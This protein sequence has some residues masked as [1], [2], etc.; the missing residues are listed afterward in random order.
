M[1]PR[2]A[3]GHLRRKSLQF[4]KDHTSRAISLE[5]MPTRAEYGQRTREE[6]S[7][8]GTSYTYHQVADFSFGA[9]A[10]CEDNI[11]FAMDFMELITTFL[12][13]QSR[14]RHCRASKRGKESII[15]VKQTSVRY[16]YITA[17]Q[18]FAGLTR[19]G[20]A[21]SAHKKSE[22]SN[23]VQNRSNEDQSDRED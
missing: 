4:R 12:V 22:L 1:R 20:V 10:E 5:N 17:R 2:I 14:T 8:P 9:E 6:S 19:S 16:G 3:E 11:L 23:S 7:K 21:S 18:H 13:E 15:I